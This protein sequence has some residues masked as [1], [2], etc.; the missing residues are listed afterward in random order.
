MSLRSF[1]NGARGLG[2]AMKPHAGCALVAAVL[3]CGLW[4]GLSSAAAAEVGN[5]ESREQAAR[6]LWD[7]GERLYRGG[8]HAQALATFKRITEEHSA[9]DFAQPAQF[10]LALCLSSLDRLDEAATAYRGVAKFPHSDWYGADWEG[11]AQ[12]WLAKLLRRQGKIEEAIAAY[13]TATDWKNTWRG[14]ALR[15]LASLHRM[16]GEY[17]AAVQA[18]LDLAHTSSSWIP[19]GLW[20]MAETYEQAGQVEQCVEQCEKLARLYPRS[21]LTARALL[22]LAALHAERGRTEAT[23]AIH[24]QVAR[25]FAGLPEGETALWETGRF[26]EASGAKLAAADAYRR[27][28]KSCHSESTIA[29]Q[30]AERLT[31]LGFAVPVVTGRDA[32]ILI[33]E[34]HG[35]ARTDDLSA[36]G[37]SRWAGQHEVLKALI[38]AGYR[39]H[40]LRLGHARLTQLDLSRYAAVIIN[41]G[42]DEVPYTA[43]EA[44]RLTDYV[45]GGGGL[46]VVS[47]PWPKAPNDL[48]AVFGLGFRAEDEGYDTAWPT[49]ISAGAESEL[50]F[51]P[52]E[53][54][55]AVPAEVIGNPDAVLAYRD[56]TPLIAAVKRGRGVVVAAGV[57]SGFMGIGL[58]HCGD[59]ADC[60]NLKLLIALV[61]WMIGETRSDVE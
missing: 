35:E 26:F 50:S 49:A 18:Y 11:G 47:G 37:S 8:E 51:L 10:R 52:E 58:R 42:Q 45:R 20:G 30:A 17:E 59:S 24:R 56:D 5:Q 38:E 25:Q 61:S 19:T 46:L 6:A 41:G 40:V 1:R 28:V 13:R 48:I 31:A 54:H 33:D 7:E 9:T 43:E 12:Y 34:T 21:L 15:E 60:D 2:R 55:V 3:T 14:W 22:R 36:D 23:L 27:L 39:V 4:V 32:R 57:G 53:I 16:R 44:T 29:K